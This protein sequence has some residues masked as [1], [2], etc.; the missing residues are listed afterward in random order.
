[1]KTFDGN[2]LDIGFKYS[3][4]IK[5]KYVNFEIIGKFKRNEYYTYD[6]ETYEGF[7][8]SETFLIVLDLHTFK[9]FEISK[10]RLLNQINGDLKY[11]PE[12]RKFILM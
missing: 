5:N 9:A 6:F 1:M 8:N 3:K 4:L 10:K 12:Y 11:L 7:L 2:L